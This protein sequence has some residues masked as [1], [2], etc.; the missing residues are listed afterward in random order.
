MSTVC[1]LFLGHPRSVFRSLFPIF[2]VLLVFGGCSS[3][4]DSRYPPTY[5]VEGKITFRG[6]PVEG[7]T[8]LFNRTDQARGAVGESDA[9]GTYRLTTYVL[10]DGAPAGEYQIQIMKYEQPPLD[11][12]EEDYYYLKNLLPEKYADATKSDLTATVEEISKN[13]IDFELE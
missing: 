10:G 12:S 5:V 7:A 13:A 11:A 2:L 1:E 4:S 3:N 9:K 8:I 6:E